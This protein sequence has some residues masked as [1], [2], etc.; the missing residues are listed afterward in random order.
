[1]KVLKKSPHFSKRRGVTIIN[2][3]FNPQLTIKSEYSNLIQIITS[4]LIYRWNK[5]ITHQIEVVHTL[6]DIDLLKGQGARKGTG[7]GN[8][9][10]SPAKSHDS[11]VRQSHRPRGQVATSDIRSVELASVTITTSRRGCHRRKGVIGKNKSTRIIPR[12]GLRRRI[13]VERTR[14]SDEE[15][16]TW[17]FW[18]TQN[19]IFSTSNS[20]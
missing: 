8:P 12:T 2:Y 11:L 18:Q 4:C 15:A 5:N 13:G 3:L 9:A 17:L 10:M 16:R 20:K 14:P 19:T 7:V 1:L 6:S